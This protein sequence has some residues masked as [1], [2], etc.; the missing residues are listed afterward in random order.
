[1]GIPTG[2]LVQDTTVVGPH[3]FRGG[4][5]S[6][7]IVLYRVENGNHARDLLQFAETIGSALG[8][9]ANVEMLGKVGGTVLDA[10]SN[11]MKLKKTVPVA[12]QR[13][14]FDSGIYPGFRSSFFV[15]AAD[16]ALD[17][18]RLRVR[19]RRLY[20]VDESG[21]ER[22][23]DESDFIL[24]SVIAR[25]RR[26][27]RTTLPFHALAQ[28]AILKAASGTEEGWANAKTLLSSAYLQMI[29]CNDV[30]V[31]ET[32]ELLG[33]YKSEM[34]EKHRSGTGITSMT[35]RQGKRGAAKPDRREATAL[36][37]LK[38]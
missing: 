4:K 36:E 18:S 9:P 10:V 2:L 24:Y 15:L 8:V 30:I 25:P 13:I 1:M 11:L 7:S 28:Q 26:G 22:R 35:D 31:D 20:I 5:L 33:A 23:Y 3:P 12:G 32:E 16:S 29:S 37:L 17:I 6:L 14:E 38:L 21:K 34:F 27:N 19:E